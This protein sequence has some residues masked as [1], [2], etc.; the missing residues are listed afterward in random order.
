MNQ[1]KRKGHIKDGRSKRVM[2][3]IIYTEKEH[4]NIRIQN[5]VVE[6]TVTGNVSD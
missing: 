5:K 4:R 1:K 2:K 6:R 3:S